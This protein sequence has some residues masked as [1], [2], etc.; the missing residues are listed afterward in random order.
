M[1]NRAEDIRVAPVTASLAGAVRALRVADDQ[2]PYVG[3]I[4][5]NLDG[6]LVDP[7][8]EA[9]AI[10]VDDSVAG[11]YRVDHAPSFLGRNRLGDA[12]TRLCLGL[13]AFLVDRRL[14]GRGIGTRAVVACCADLQRR[15]P[16]QRL[17]ALSVNCRNTAAIRAYRRAGFVDTGELYLGGRAGPQ[18]LM[19]RRLGPMNAGSA[20]GQSPP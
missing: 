9:M 6:A 13:R 1:P 2:V 16:Q 20:V 4:D 19:V 5:V 17:L 18:H 12:S 8:S 11:F 10:L 15:H 7:R 14:Q 3:D